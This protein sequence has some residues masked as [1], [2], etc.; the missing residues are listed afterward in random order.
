VEDLTRALE[1]VVRREKGRVVGGL[2][3][4]FGN[5]D[6][7][8]EAFQDAVVAALA[9]WPTDG[10]PDNPAAWLTATA[11]N[12]A[13][14]AARH[15]GVVK[16]KAGL[17]KTNETVAPATIESVSDD[18][19]RLIFTCCHPALTLDSQVALTL[20]VV[21]G[22]GTD[23]IARAFLSP[24]KTVAQRLTR[25]KAVIQEKNLPYEVPERAELPQRL[26]SVLAVVYLIFNEGHTARAGTLMRVDLQEEALRLARLLCDL[27]PN[28]PETFAL[29]ALVAFSLARAASRTD[30][31][32][33]VLLLAQQDRSRWNRPLIKE[34]LMALARAR[35]LGGRES[36]R[37][38]AE[39]AACHV[40]APTWEDTDWARILAAYDQLA[41]SSPSPV[42]A[43]NRAIALS[44]TAGPDAALAAL[45]PLEAPLHQYH[46]FYATRADLRRRLGQDP[47]ADHAR[48]LALAT[49]EG[50]RR[51]LQRQLEDD[52]RE[53]KMRSPT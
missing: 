42:V 29:L 35:R 24:E 5:L 16:R 50:E 26:A 9:R 34:A 49:N 31:R 36:Y 19:L 3:R 48:A 13:L 39:I 11:R 37:W 21:A 4:L 22:F 6:A 25:A 8:E 53:R 20:K 45:E 38:Q 14:D 41:A 30:E 17:L 46:L 10:T 51:F 18:L 27:L 40:T 15:R 33:E 12:H 32:G 1:D 52:Q 2:V 44:M 43:L 28:E 47:R 23:E 7:A